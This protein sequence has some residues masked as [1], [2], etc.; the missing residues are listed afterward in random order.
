MKRT[1]LYKSFTLLVFA[2]FLFTFFKS[3]GEISRQTF[4]VT[5]PRTQYILESSNCSQKTGMILTMCSPDRGPV[6]VES[7]SVADDR[8]HNLIAN[9]VSFFKTEP[10]SVK[11]IVHIGLVINAIGLLAVC[12]G[13]LVAQMPVA[14]VLSLYLGT[15]HGIPGP[16]VGSESAASYFGVYC[17]AVAPVIFLAGRMNKK[18]PLSH[19]YFAGVFILFSLGSAI[20]LRQSLGMLGIMSSLAILGFG[21]FNRK[22]MAERMKFIAFA[23]CLIALTGLPEGL[24]NLRGW[25]HDVPRGNLIGTH[26]FAHTLYAGLG[27]EPNPWG[28]KW[29]DS[30]VWEQIHKY[31]PK[32]QYGTES[33]FSTAKEMYMNI[34][35]TSP[36]EV[37]K[38][39]WAKLKIITTGLKLQH[40]T[41]ATWLIVTALVLLLGSALSLGDKTIL[42]M[43]SGLYVGTFLMILQGVLATYDDRYI[44]PARF[45]V[46]LLILCVLEWV[47]RFDFRFKKLL[48]WRTT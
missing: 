46:V 38:I 39:Y 3:W 5:S 35:K 29:D 16:F 20:L 9:I 6:G 15:F 2:F 45:A 43:T 42:M 28:I 14:A 48:V 8:G 12:F 18:G 33:H 44:Y 7:Y 1:L 19:E 31:N 23:F 4:E 25:M 21:F 27:S 37:A 17:L 11:T 22:N 13:F 32:A 41:L 30:L 10:L 36:L 34:L 24:L 40:G 26:G 47:L